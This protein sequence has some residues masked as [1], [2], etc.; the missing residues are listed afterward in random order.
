[1]PRVVEFILPVARMSLGY[2]DTLLKEITPA[3]FA[4]LP[5]GL[6]TNHPAFVYGHLSVYPDKILPDLGFASIAKPDQKWIDL[7]EAGAVCKDDPSGTIYPAMETIV[8]RFRER[9][10]ALLEAL[11]GV[12]DDT[13]AAINPNE[14][15]RQRLPTLGARLNF[16]LTGHMMMHLGQI[17]AWRRMMGLGSA[18]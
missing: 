3:I 6:Q 1:M 15:A 13:L 14:Q 7:F 9:H 2:A 8:G 10:A 18:M 16:Y 5:Q 11:P 12:S 4:R 17:S